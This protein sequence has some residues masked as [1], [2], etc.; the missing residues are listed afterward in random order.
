MNMSGETETFNSECPICLEEPQTAIEL[1]CKHQMCQECFDHLRRNTCSMRFNC[2]LCRKVI[3]VAYKT[4]IKKTEGN[5]VIK[6]RVIY[7][8]ARKCRVL[9]KKDFK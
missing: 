4:V 6:E 3:E 5:N 2:T 8:D 1:P 7:Y 9:L